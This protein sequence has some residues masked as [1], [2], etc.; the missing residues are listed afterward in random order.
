MKIRSAVALVGLA[1]SFA[2]PT[3]AQA[4]NT[5][6]PQV[7]EEIEALSKKFQEAYDKHDAAAIAALYTEDAVEVR[8]W[9]AAQGGGTFSGRK[10]I[11]RMFVDHFEKHP[12]KVVSELVN[13]YMTGQGVCVI[14]NLSAVDKVRQAVRIYDPDASADLWKI[15]MTYV[16]F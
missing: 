6:A 10:A 2:L 13:A 15:R 7:R 5:V 1:I 14:M 9:P 11:E 4:Q 12:G 8:S 3:F 16:S